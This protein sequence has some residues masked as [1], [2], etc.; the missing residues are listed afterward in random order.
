M[1]PF[2]LDFFNNPFRVDIGFLLKGD[3]SHRYLDERCEIYPIFKTKSGALIGFQLY[4]VIK[5]I[6]YDNDVCGDFYCL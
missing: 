1:T 5:T 3:E 2:V 4:P 6:Y